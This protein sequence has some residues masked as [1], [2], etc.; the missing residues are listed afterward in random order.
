MTEC[1]E[2]FFSSVCSCE[3]A[4]GDEAG[5]ERNGRNGGEVLEI[6]SFIPA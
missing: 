3:S 5:D 1:R 4:G 2:E 6:F